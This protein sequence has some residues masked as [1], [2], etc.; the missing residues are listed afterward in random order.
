[1]R[2]GSAADYCFGIE[3][4]IRLLEVGA[5]TGQVATTLAKHWG[6]TVITLELWESL[7][8]IQEYASA[9]NAENDVLA[10]KANAELMPFPDEA[11]DAVFSIGSFFY[12]RG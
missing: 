12:H 1:M 10:V 5:G 9:K 11:F 3:A 4:G 2:D 8:V 6:V 7:N